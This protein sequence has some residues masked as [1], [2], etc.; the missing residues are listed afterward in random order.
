MKKYATLLIAC[1]LIVCFISTGCR[2][3]RES[4]CPIIPADAFGCQP[5]PESNSAIGWNYFL[6]ARFL[7]TATYNPNNN[8]EFAY[9]TS[10]YNAPGENDTLFIFNQATGQSR[11]ILVAG[12]WYPPQ[13]GHNGWILLGLAGGGLAMIK[14]NGD[15][16]SDISQGRG[17]YHHPT[18]NASCTRIYAYS[19][20]G[21]NVLL[22][23]DGTVADS[24]RAG[25][26]DVDFLDD[27]RFF[28]RLGIYSISARQYII[29]ND[30]ALQEDFSAKRMISADEV[31][32]SDEKGIHKTNLS[33]NQTVIVKPSCNSRLYMNPS[34][35]ASRTKVLWTRVNSRGDTCGAD[36][37]YDDYNIVEM[38]PDGTGEREIPIPE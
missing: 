11:N 25:A 6:V 2:K 26:E 18:W 8:N 23:L 33:S 37:L 32:W 24:F 31:I 12:M 30:A 38:N 36:K 22:N 5:I 20:D 34:V 15:S 4:Q 21:P 17:S 27:D 14:P 29:R 9:W 13:W 3:P 16:L 28:A 7:Q 19:F 10:N 1:T 35:N